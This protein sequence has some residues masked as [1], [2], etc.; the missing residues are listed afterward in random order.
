LISKDLK[1]LARASDEKGAA[2]MER[3]GADRVISLYATGAAKVAQLLANPKVEDFLEIVTTRGREL[4]LAEI[5]IAS[6]SIYAGQTLAQTDFSRRGI[7]IVGIRRP[8]GDLLLPPPST[9][10]IESGD[11]LIA[12]GKTAAIEDL[13]AGV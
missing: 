11:S 1:I 12:L 3:A 7:M 8:E 6:D 2:K 10:L 9:A 4:D 5:Q 13:C